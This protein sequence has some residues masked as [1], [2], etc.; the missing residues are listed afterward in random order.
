MNNDRPLIYLDFIAIECG[1]LDPG[2][3]RG[4]RRQFD[5]DERQHEP[6]VKSQPQEQRYRNRDRAERR[7]DR[8]AQPTAARPVPLPEE[9]RRAHTASR[10]RGVKC[11]RP[12]RSCCSG[13]SA[14]LRNARS[15]ADL[16]NMSSVDALRCASHLAIV[17]T[18]FDSLLARFRDPAVAAV[19]MARQCANSTHQSR[20]W[21][22]CSAASRNAGNRSPTS[23]GFMRV[24]GPCTETAATTFSTSFITGTAIQQM[25]ARYSS[26]STA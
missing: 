3:R 15:R 10:V 12:L 24:V 8:D 21:P 9:S 5:A 16:F 17:V 14:A 20:V 22:I 1:D 4:E 13:S 11:S 19:A 2:E 6:A 23:A 18:H 25:P 26:L 7:E